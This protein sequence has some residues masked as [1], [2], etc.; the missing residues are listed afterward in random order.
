ML[1]EPYWAI[2]AAKALGVEAKWPIQY[3]Y[4]VKSMAASQKR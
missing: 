1:R 4:A 2:K 3:G